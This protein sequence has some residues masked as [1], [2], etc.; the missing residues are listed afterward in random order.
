MLFTG[1]EILCEGFSE[2]QDESLP[3]DRVLCVLQSGMVDWEPEAGSVDGVTP[4]HRPF[5]APSAAMLST[6]GTG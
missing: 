6:R 2:I 3:A 4:G 5:S 1:L